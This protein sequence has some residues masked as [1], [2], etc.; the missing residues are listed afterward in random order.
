[1]L[2]GIQVGGGR[3]VK[4]WEPA[5]FGELVAD[6]AVRYRARFVFTGSE[7]D[8]AV[9]DAALATAPRTIPIVDLVGRADIPT[10]AAVLERLSLFITGD[11]GPMHLAAAVGTPIVAIFGP[12]D[13]LRWGPLAWRP[14]ACSNEAGAEAR[15]VHSTVACRPCN[16]IRRPP[17][18]CVGHV[19]DCLD[20]VTVEQV[21]R[22]VDTVLG[23]RTHVSR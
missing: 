7:R 21:A 17:A 18:R 8:R 19:P 20:A 1:M 16:R 15:V 22:E 12:S 14:L 6:L 4:Q 2:I 10:L 5:R 13:P 9:T 23:A 3:D 11:T